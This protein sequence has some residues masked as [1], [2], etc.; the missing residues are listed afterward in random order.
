MAGSGN[1]LQDYFRFI[2]ISL[3]LFVSESI[4]AQE[5]L[6]GSSQ[7]LQAAGADLEA[8]NIMGSTPLILAAHNSHLEIAE[9]RL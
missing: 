8:S 9:V 4:S 5:L 6:C 1:K 7:V 2:L 3:G